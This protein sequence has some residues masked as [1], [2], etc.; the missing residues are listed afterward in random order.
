MKIGIIAA[1]EQ[2]LRLLVDQ[3]T[4]KKKKQFFRLPT[5]L[6]VWESMTWF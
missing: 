4:H 5:I 3:L 1:M 2:E 6:D